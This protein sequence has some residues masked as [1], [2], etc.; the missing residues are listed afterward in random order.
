MKNFLSL[1]LLLISQSG[2]TLEP[3]GESALER[4]YINLDWDRASDYQVQS[5]FISLKGVICVGFDRK[6]NRLQ[7][8]HYRDDSGVAVSAEINELIKRDV[9]FLKRSDFPVVAQ[10]ATRNVDPLTIK[11]SNETITNNFTDYTVHL[12]F[13][14]NMVKGLSATDL[15]E[16]KLQARSYTDGRRYLFT[17]NS[18]NGNATFNKVSLII[19]NDLKISTINLFDDQVR[20]QKL[21]TALLPRSSRH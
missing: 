19:G 1:L 7:R 9:V 17:G 18:F 21:E 15:R 4:K 16:L 5:P 13:V 12:K 3:C 6:S 8:L 11:I 2:F 10:L 20:V 14:R